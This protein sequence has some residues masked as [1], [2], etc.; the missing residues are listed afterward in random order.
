[1]ST[2]LPRAMLVAWIVL[3]TAGFVG[4]TARAVQAQVYLT[5]EQALREIFP[6][7]GRTETEHRTLTSAALERL[8]QR[9]GRPVPGA[10]REITRVFDANGVFL[11]YAVIA[12]EIGKY[13]PI[14]FMV[15]VT[16]D[17]SVRDVAVMVYR[18]SR[19]GDVRRE[20]FLSQYRGKSTDD[21]I[22][23]NRDIINISGATISV[24][25]MNFGVKRVLAE[26]EELYAAPMSAARQR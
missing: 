2:T 7:A 13:R 8:E 24:R 26:L 9:L 19:G 4:P 14:T 5:P 15:G 21:H 11:G 6:E 25:S 22:T 1:M 3:G 18:E 17:F 20:R 10:Q 16:P 12:H 23:T